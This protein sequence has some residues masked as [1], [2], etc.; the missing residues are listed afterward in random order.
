MYWD[1]YILS[2]LMSDRHEKLKISKA[3]LLHSLT[4]QILN[5]GIF[6]LPFPH[7]KGFVA[8]W[9]FIQHCIPSV[10]NSCRLPIQAITR[11][12]TSSVS[13]I[14]YM[15]YCNILLTSLSAFTTTP[16][17]CSRHSIQGDTIKTHKSQII[18]L[19]SKPSNSSQSF[20][21][22][23]SPYSGP[24]PSYVWLLL[25]SPSLTQHRQFLRRAFYT[26]G[27]LCKE[28]SS[29]SYLHG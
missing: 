1:S 27:F 11:I 17:V 7:A 2:H 19:F 22:N 20:W 12:T 13:N 10:K 3:K 8:I 21:E 18:A 9:L 6:I 14:S 26:G 5:N 25:F 28:C 23:E 4:T 16:T 15:D 24:I 29:P